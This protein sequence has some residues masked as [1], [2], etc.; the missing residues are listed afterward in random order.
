MATRTGF[1]IERKF[2]VNSLPDD[3][4]EY[5]CK[6]MVQGYLATNSDDLHIRIR[7]AGQRYYLTVK[8]GQGLFRREVEIELQRDQ[9]E[10]LWPLTENRHVEK[11][12]YYIPWNGYTLELDVYVGKLEGLYTLEVEFATRSE[13]ERFQQPD[14]VGKEVTDDRRYENFQ[15][16]QSGIPG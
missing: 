15:L 12:R 3:I 6:P 8:S 7:Q 13:A 5:S 4:Q 14:W 9:F 11:T 1:E 10:A 16:A 2:I